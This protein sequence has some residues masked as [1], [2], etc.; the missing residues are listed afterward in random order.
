[1]FGS[2]N[3]FWYTPFISP[4]KPNQS[5]QFAS[6]LDENV[7][8]LPS[9]ISILIIPVIYESKQ[10]IGSVEFKLNVTTNLASTNLTY[11]LT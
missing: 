4:S 11:L 1:V 10:F 6:I 8:I 7:N 3:T 2:A 5:S 9:S